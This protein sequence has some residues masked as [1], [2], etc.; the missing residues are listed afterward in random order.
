M[1]RERLERGLIQVYT[2]ESKG[3][4]TAA[5]GL[6]LRA[7]GHGFRVRMISFMKGGMYT[8]ELYAAPRL[9]PN[10][11]IQQF[12]RGC[13]YAGPIRDGLMKCLPG[14]RVCFLHRDDVNEQ[15]REM[16]AL[17][18]RQA[19]AAILAGEEDIVILDEILNAFKWGLADVGATVDLLGRKPE[20]VEVVLTGRQ[21]PPEVIA[22]AHLVTEMRSIKHP[23][24]EQGIRARR[25]IEY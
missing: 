14:C 17:A 23:Y 24:R 9:Y 2:G 22:V 21:A 20:H 12:G 4:T 13:P 7:A 25:G 6:A 15:D 5:L 8:G 10:L 18:F 19:E 3:K 1:T 11:T 16:A